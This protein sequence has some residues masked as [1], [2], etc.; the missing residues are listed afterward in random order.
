V[1][2][3]LGIRDGFEREEEAEVNPGKQEFFSI[4]YLA[5]G[6][7]VKT[8][9]NGNTILNGNSSLNGQVPNRG[10]VNQNHE[11]MRKPKSHHL[12]TRDTMRPL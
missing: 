11:I 7:F 8:F 9:S 1:R 4:F 10:H 3:F 6:A 2:T 5:Q 12:T